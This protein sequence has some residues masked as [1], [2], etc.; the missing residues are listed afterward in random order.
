ME[1]YIAE[2]E[3]FEKKTSVYDVDLAVTDKRNFPADLKIITITQTKDP[4]KCSLYEVRQFKNAVINRST[5]NDY[6]IYLK[7]ISCSSVKITLAIPSEVYNTVSYGLD[8]VFMATHKIVQFIGLSST[9]E[10]TAWSDSDDKLCSSRR[11]YPPT[12]AL[13]RQ[14]PRHIFHCSASPSTSEQGTAHLGLFQ[15][16]RE[17]QFNRRV[18]SNFSDHLGTFYSSNHTTGNYSWTSNHIDT[19]FPS[20]GE[21]VPT[22]E[23]TQF[24]PTPYH[25]QHDTL[26]TLSLPSIEPQH[27]TQPH[28]DDDSSIVHSEGQESDPPEPEEST[29]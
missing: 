5:L 15:L 26:D 16:Q 10:H 18:S 21:Y 14:V 29:K 2:L 24:P 13:V 23:T 25:P 9:M 7:G 19:I 1:K 22:Q 8:A 4:K 28:T 12:S 17:T 20:Q 11:S 6:A 27:D 3:T